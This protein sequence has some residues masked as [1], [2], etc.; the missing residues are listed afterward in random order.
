MT[1]DSDLE[2]VREAYPDRE[3]PSAERLA[4]LRAR[5]VEQIDTSVPSQTRTPSQRSPRR[6]GPRRRHLIP[7][8]VGLA[9]V[10]VGVA[11]L[12]VSPGSEGP[13]R[14][15]VA[16]ARAILRGAAAGLAVPAGAVLHTTYTAV[17][18]FPN[19]RSTRW[20]EDDWQET[21]PPYSKR[22][23]FS[24]AGQPSQEYTFTAGRMQLYDPQRNTIYTNESP[25]P[26]TVRPAARAGRYLL[27]PAGTRS[28]ITI[29]A[30][31]LRGLRDG[32]DTIVF[33]NQPF[34]IP[35]SSLVKPPLDIRTI[36]LSLLRSGH[37]QVQDH[38]KFAGRAAIEISGPGRVPGIQ[39]S[40]YVAPR[41]YQP[42]GMVQRFHGAT[43]TLRFTA[44]QLLPVTVANRALVTLPGA[45]PSAR[46]DTSAADY[47]AAANRL[48][49]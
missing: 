27:T 13:G 48:L 49:K 23:I 45:H 25:P 41:T 42:L 36:A 20:R 4:S 19:G 35:Y 46:I 21:S 37:A 39:N 7:W 8:A 44:Y 30:T 40:Y 6:R 24:P 10:V 47:N 9:A 18:P 32:Q 16:E 14:P 33:S 22:Y 29:T 1:A 11:L 34:V 28:T 12:I 15:G 5:L 17:Q 26:Y 3:E 2:R 31:Q 38:V 43:V